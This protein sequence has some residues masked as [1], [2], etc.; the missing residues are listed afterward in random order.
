MTLRAQIFLGYLLVSVLLLFVAAAGYWGI[1]G[2][3]AQFDQAVN[4]TQPVVSVLQGIHDLSTDLFLDSV[5]PDEV[6]AAFDNQKHVHVETDGGKGKDEG[7]DEPQ[8]VNSPEAL[9]QRVAAYRHLVQVYFQD[10]ESDAQEID[11]HSVAFITALNAYQIGKKESSKDVDLLLATLA[12]RHAALVESVAEA[13]EGEIEEF[14]ELQGSVDVIRRDRLQMIV[15]A[16]VLAVMLAVGIGA[17]L[18]RR[19]SRP[20]VTLREASERLGRGVL[21]TRVPVEAKNEIGALGEAFNEMAA[22][23]SSS[24]YSRSYVEGILESLSE[25][26]LV[27]DDTGSI[28]RCNSAMCR[29]Y[30]EEAFGPLI[31][32]M[33]RDLFSA[34]DSVDEMLSVASRRQWHE[35]CLSGLRPE[36][37]IVA[38]TTSPIRIGESWKGRVLLVQDVTERRRHEDRLTYLASYDVLT[39]LANRRL[40]LEQA[41]NILA[42]LPWSGRYAGVLFCDLDRFKFINDSLG[43]DVGDV[44]LKHVAERFKDEVRPGDIVGRWAADEFVI[45]LGDV[46]RTED[47]A[48]VAGKLVGCLREPIQVGPHE[49]FLTLS[50]GI[51]C[52]PIDGL[53]AEEL[54]SNADMAMFAA[55]AAGRNVFVFFEP[56][57]RAHSELRL[58]LEHALRS[59]IEG[60]TQLQVHYQPQKRINGGLIGFEA[61]VRWQHPELGLISPAQFL[62]AAEEAGLMAALDERVLRMACIE[63]RRWH[64]A[65]WVD[66]RVA[67]NVSN[68]SFRRDDLAAVVQQVISSSGI[69][70]TSLE[71]ELTEEIVMGNVGV[72][73]A[74]MHQLR[75]IGVSLSIDDFGTGYSSLGQLKRCPITLLKIDRSFI[76][77]V[78]TDVNDKAITDAIIALSHILGIDVLA[79]GVE[80]EEQLIFLRNCGCDAIQGYLLSR[81]MPRDDV[82]E[83][84][85]RHSV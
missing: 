20:L 32:R 25:G 41:K 53:D 18:A 80:T 78:T 29:L 84:I 46:S 16:A 44:L 77:D 14:A 83:F 26:I 45:L 15:A 39:G 19:I 63:L 7:D 28:E 85:G 5:L 59:A 75:A 72:A 37:V 70:A 35:L 68:Q 12:Q 43:H 71:L 61:L 49:I 79:E 31:G 54:V 11:E 65:G 21:E 30:D 8:R 58:Q 6:R 52:A 1:G 36:R 40:F 4:R 23:L 66:L 42:R 34:D 10:E 62:P 56:E 55:K 51:S 9:M 81:P 24:M 13:E 48:I 27:V 74:T 3:A 2:V 33:V 69:P 38:V 17:L 67:V 82:L 73:V 76:S 57:M 47:L 22:Q 50:I 64:D 60:G